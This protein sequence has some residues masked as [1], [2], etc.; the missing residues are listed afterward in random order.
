MPNIN[1][2]FSGDRLKADDLKKP[3]GT[4]GKIQATVSAVNVVELRSGKDDTSPLTNKLEMHF[5]GKDKTFIVNKTNA[6]NIAM[7]LGPD[8]DNWIGAVIGIDVHAT[9]LGPGLRAQVLQAPGQVPQ[10]N[11]TMA[12]SG[13][14]QLGPPAGSAMNDTDLP[15]G[16]PGFDGS[17]LED[18]IPF[19]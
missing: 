10:Q 19:N 7:T 1:D 2:V 4:Y 6:T 13:A 8:T 18:D 9:Q 3:D 14:A 5:V 11:A 16:E 15:V 12:A 17:D